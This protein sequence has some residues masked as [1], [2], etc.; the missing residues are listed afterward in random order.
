VTA[1]TLGDALARAAAALEAGDAVGAAAAMAEAGRACQQAQARGE[2]VER[3]ALA[4]LAALHAR[5]ERGMLRTRAT[6]EQALEA[7]GSARR[8]VTA[9]RRP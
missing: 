6:L 4:V 5:C 3:D 9:Y 2:R 7:A 8:A 1:E